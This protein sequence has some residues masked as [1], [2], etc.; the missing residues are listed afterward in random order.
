MNYKTSVISRT[1]S[2]AGPGWERLLAQGSSLWPTWKVV[3]S[4]DLPRAPLVFQVEKHVS[5]D[6]PWASL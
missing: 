1:G 2:R 4:V 3:A 6:T 5:L